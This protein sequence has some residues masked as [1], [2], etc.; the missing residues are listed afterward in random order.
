MARGN[1]LLQAIAAIFALLAIAVSADIPG[2]SAQSSST[3]LAIDAI[4]EGN[5]ATSLGPIDQ[6]VSVEEG[7]SFTVDVVIED[8]P[9]L[10]TWEATVAH[11]RQL[12]EITDQ[13][14]LLMIAAAAGSSPFN[15]SESL[16]DINGTH[17]VGA[18]DT[19][20]LESGSGVL[21]RVT[22]RALAAGT[23]DISIPQLDFNGDGTTDFGVIVQAAGGVHLGDTNGDGFF[24]GDVSGA[25]VRIGSS[26]DNVTPRPIAQPTPDPDFTPATL[27]PAPDDDGAP[28]PDGGA[29]GGG[30]GGGTSPTAAPAQSSPRP[31]GDS[32]SPDADA[33]PREGEDGPS[34]SSGGGG[35]SEGLS[36]WL[37]GLFAVVVVAITST[38][39]IAARAFSR[40]V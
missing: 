26:C 35:D 40:R 13:D 32:A 10:L 25:V 33:S 16:P 36:A 4:T 23:S 2:A 28:G 8:V 12:L 19:R 30:I 5:A 3:S 39:L 38:G 22:F 6:C 31:S 15:G 1:A 18:T 21:A 27:A 24:D 14:P 37:L 29:G 7:D 11:D 34:S 17:F 20:A 9:S